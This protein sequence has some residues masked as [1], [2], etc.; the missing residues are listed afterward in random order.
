MQLPTDPRAQRSVMT[1]FIVVGAALAIVRMIFVM[2]WSV[3]GEHGLTENVWVE[4]GLSVLSDLILA[5]V[6]G[7][8]VI[9]FGR[10]VRDSVTYEKIASAITTYAVSTLALLLLA[11]LVPADIIDGRPSN[12][13]AVISSN[14]VAI[15]AFAI[16]IVLAGFLTS[17]LLMRR[18][19]RTRLYLVLQVFILFAI[20]LCSV[21]DDVSGLFTAAAVFLAIIGAVITLMNIRR[22]SWLTTITLDKKIRLLWLTA[23]GAF[24]SVVL[25]GMLAFSDDSYLTMSALTFLRNGAVLP[26]AI[27]M[28]GFVFFLRLFF[29]TITSLPNS[30]I[31]D[32]RSSEVE[33]LSTVTRLIAESARVDDLMASVTAHALRVC[34]AHGAWCELYDASD[35]RIVGEQLVHADYVMTLHANRRLHRLFTTGDRPVHVESVADIF[36]GDDEL[37]AIRSLIIIPIV[38]HGDRAGTLVMFS[39]IEYG[40]EADDVRLLAALSDTVGVGLD[41]ARLMEAALEKERLQKEFDVARNIQA[42]LL[43]RKPPSTSCCDVDAVT[44]P[45]AQVGGDYF[46]YVRFKNGRLGAII[47]DV[48]GKGIPAALYMATLKGTVLAEMRM[49]E[50]PA[51]LLRRINATLFG[52]MERHTY[53]TMLCVEFDENTHTLRVARAGHTPAILRVGTELQ[54]LTPQGVAIGIVAPETFDHVICE[55]AVE[56]SPGD[57]CLLTTDGV[58]ER[59]DMNYSEIGAEKIGE[60]LLNISPTSSGELVRATVKLLDQYGGE[61][62]QHDDITIVGVM[63]T[64]NCETLPETPRMHD[65]VGAIV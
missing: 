61:M 19:E 34:R 30:G 5:A 56:V 8:T 52:S 54:Y 39:T 58:T 55:E 33:I 24:A 3:V 13:G 9:H 46:D 32:R 40:F 43:P 12:I 38:N 22:L 51:D 62:E 65:I 4:I 20:W 10:L 48:S 42:S 37:P 27:N 50:G 17:L 21:L 29:A 45:A 60:M 49:A 53:I 31:V 64:D 44:I 41:Q 15:G 63:F 47:A 14:L 28:F 57:L 23:C 18:H 36:D 16:S 2:L 11:A 25:S 26:A 7:A 35:I 1:T 6:V 59:R